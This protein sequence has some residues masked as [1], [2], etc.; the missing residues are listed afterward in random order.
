MLAVSLLDMSLDEIDLGAEHEAAVKSCKHLKDL[1][2]EFKRIK[3]NPELEIDMVI[4]EL[5]NKI[6]LRR[7]TTKLE[8]DTEAI[9]LIK[10]LDDYGK[11]TKAATC[12]FENPTDKIEDQI[13]SL[14]KNIP[15]WEKELSTFK[16]SIKRWVE[17]QGV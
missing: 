9:S 13:K 11:K 12:N 5:K 2:Q 7:E 3:D 16:S 14:E 17:I 6:D 15:V 1:Y 4:E 8:I 10:E